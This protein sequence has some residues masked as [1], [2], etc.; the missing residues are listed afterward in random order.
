MKKIIFLYIFFICVAYSSKADHITGG[1]IF[2]TLKS[3]SGNQFTYTITIKMYMACN[4]YREF[5]NPT[6]ISVFDKRTNARIRDMMV[7]IT[8][9]EIIS[10]DDN[11]EC[12]VNPPEVCHRIGYYNF[13]MTL[14]ASV[15]GYVLTSEVFFRVSRRYP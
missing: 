14:P 3:V 9:I 10:L 11:K 13:D 1:E 12:I 15:D 7:P 2:Y 5:Y 8:N 4:T 6:Y